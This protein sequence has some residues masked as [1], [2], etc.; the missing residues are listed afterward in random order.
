M[1]EAD[2]TW[3]EGTQ[4]RYQKNGGVFGLPRSLVQSVDQRPA[5]PPIP[6]SRRRASGSS[7]AT[8]PGAA[9]LLR[10]VLAR[11]AAIDRRPA[12]AGGSAARR[13][14][15]RRARA[16]RPRARPR[17]DDNDPRSHALLGD[18]W[19]ALGERLAAQ[20]AYRRSL[21][22]GPTRRSSRS[23]P[24]SPPPPPPRP[25]PRRAQFRLRYDGGINEALG[26]AVLEVLAGA[27]DNYAARLRFRPDD[28]ITVVLEM[29]TGFQDPRAPEWAAGAQRRHHP[30]APARDGTPLRG[31]GGRAAPRARPF[32][33]PRPHRRQL[34][35]L[36]AG[37]HLAVAGGGDPRREDAA[38]AAAP[39]RAACCR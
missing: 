1:I 7:P 15:T 33:H 13:W 31:P 34:P 20:D 21:R 32:L 19:S 11:D 28:P 36:A 24:P 23:S 37:R 17:L 26:A 35:D 10:R 3:Y 27:Y 4:L 30:R 2:R 39:R 14:E 9:C 6:R 18:A 29:G 5:A 22:L 25:A 8:R 16:T 38:V 12:G